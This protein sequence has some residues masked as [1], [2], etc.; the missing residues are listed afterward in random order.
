MSGLNNQNNISLVSEP[1]VIATISTNINGKT[2]KA[3]SLI[4]KNNHIL[5]GKTTKNNEKHFVFKDALPLLT[6]IKPKKNT[7]LKHG[8]VRILQNPS[9]KKRSAIKR[10]RNTTNRT[11]NNWRTSNIRNAPNSD[12]KKRKLNGYTPI[13]QALTT[14]TV[15]INTNAFFF[16][17]NNNKKQ[18]RS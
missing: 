16:G 9:K 15:P 3:P 11:P 12:K 13:N 7:K 1:S 14:P 4:D 10:R 8:E 5:N 2:T 18:H 17:V 6:P